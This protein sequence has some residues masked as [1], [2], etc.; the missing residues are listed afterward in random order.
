MDKSKRLFLKSKRSFRRRLPPIGLGDRID[1]RNMSIISRF[2]SEQGKIL[3]RRVNR[4]T[5]KQQ[6]LITIAIKQARILSSL[7]FLN[8]EKQIERT[9][10]TPR[11]TGLRTRK[12]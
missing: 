9:E 11:T 2:I 1:Y 6:R 10:S 7:P 5:L 3:S 12:K 4:L 8:N